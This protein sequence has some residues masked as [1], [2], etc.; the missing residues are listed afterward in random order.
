LPGFAGRFFDLSLSWDRLKMY[1]SSDGGWRCLWGS[2]RGLLMLAF[3]PLGSLL[4]A[5]SHFTPIYFTTRLYGLP[6]HWSNP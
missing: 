1:G 4:F 3:A 6:L 2:S 5:P